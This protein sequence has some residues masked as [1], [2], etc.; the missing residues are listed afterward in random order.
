MTIQL[1]YYLA[2]HMLVTS[3]T[4]EIHFHD[5]PQSTYYCTRE[6][7]KPVAMAVANNQK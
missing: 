3:L 1:H 2:P 4:N 7:R 5:V 6:F